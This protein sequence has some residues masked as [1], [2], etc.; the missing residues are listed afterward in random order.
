MSSDETPRK[1]VSMTHLFFLLLVIGCVSFFIW[2]FYGKLDIVSVA[3]GEVIPTGRVKH[4][5]HLEGGIIREI[6]VKEGD[7]VKKGQPI[8]IL[9]R[10]MI[11]ASLDELN[12][13]VNSLTI[14]IIRLQ[15]VL[16]D[17]KRVAFSE[18]LKHDFPKMTAEAKNLFQTELS[19]YK[20]GVTALRHIIKQRKQRLKTGPSSP[21]TF[22]K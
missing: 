17:K 10:T 3:E 21:W 15:A 2:A 13:R 18:K 5:Q 16:E 7:R 12:A 4:V 19:H 11:G 22:G 6:A 9:E 20:S 8:I 1:K 14:D